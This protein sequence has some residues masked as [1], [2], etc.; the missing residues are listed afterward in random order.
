MI[1][2]YQGWPGSGKSL[3]LVIDALEHYRIFGL[4]IYANFHMKKWEYRRNGLK[5]EEIY[6]NNKKFATDCIYVPRKDF[7]HIL[8]TEK[9]GL[10]LVD[11]ASTIF[12]SREWKKLDPAIITRFQT[13]RKYKIDILYTT[14]NIN[15]VDITLRELTSELIECDF[16]QAR[17]MDKKYNILMK[18]KI[19]DGRVIGHEGDFTKKQ[20]LKRTRLYLPYQ[21]KKYFDMYMTLEDATLDDNGNLEGW[22]TA[23]NGFMGENSFAKLKLKSL[24][25]I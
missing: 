4:P 12:N 11:E 20:Y 22:E 19:Y 17:I 3:S 14:Q 21:L 15:R 8:K 16:L 1:I 23:I 7:L 10:F 24:L 6:L 5:R 25:G 18:N 9:K 2:G 13:S